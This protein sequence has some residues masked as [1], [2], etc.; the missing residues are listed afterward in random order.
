MVS[1]TK[2]HWDCIEVFSEADFPEDLEAIEEPTLARHGEDNQIGPVAASAEV[3][4]KLL[5]R[6]ELKR[7]LGC[8]HGMLRR[9]TGVINQDLLAF[10]RA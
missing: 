1:G 3:T 7:Y 8:A 9:H 6:G 4:V 5:R 10:V 2:A